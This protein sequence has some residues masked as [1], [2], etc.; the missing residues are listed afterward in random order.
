M[1]CGNNSPVGDLGHLSVERCGLGHGF[2]WKSEGR[3]GMCAAHFLCKV[4]IIWKESSAL[5]SARCSCRGGALGFPAPTSGGSQLL[6][7]LVPGGPD[8]HFRH[9]HPS[10]AHTKQQAH[11]CTHIYLTRFN[12]CNRKDHYWLISVI[13]TASAVYESIDWK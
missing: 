13:T 9:L 4:F 6:S 5:K 12:N 10:S 11:T 3:H 8:A 2:P 1:Y 7:T